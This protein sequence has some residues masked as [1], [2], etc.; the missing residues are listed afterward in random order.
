MSEKKVFF[1][2]RA[3]AD[4]RWAELI[5]RAVKDAGHQAFSEEDIPIGENIV[6][7][8]ARGADAYCT[9]AVLSPAYFRSEHCVA[10][11][12]SALFRDPLGRRGSVFPVRVEPVEI[13]NLYA[14]L[15][16]L[17][18]VGVN[19]DIALQKLMIT[20]VRRGQVE[21]TELPPGGRNLRMIEHAD[22]NR[23]AMIEKV[24]TIWID[25][26]LKHSLFQ[27]V[28]ILLDLDERPDA[29]ARPLDLLVRRP[30]EGERPLPA[31][32]KIVDVFDSMD[33]SLLILGAPGAGKT[34]LLLEL[35]RDLLDRAIDN[36]SHPIPVVFPLST[37]AESQKSL[38]EWLA[39]ELNLRYDV[40][41]KIAQEWVASDQVL[42]LLDGLDE[43]KAEHRAAC[44]KVINAFR[45]S[46]GF[47]PLA[48]ASRTTDYESLADPIRL[49]GAIV[50]R[51]LTREQVI[52][53]LTELGS[54]GESVR[55]AV[56]EDQSL[57]ELLVSP[58]LL[59]V[60][61]VAHAGRREVPLPMSGTAGDR[62]N[63]IF[64]VYVDQMLRRRTT[65]R[66][67]T[68]KQTVH[69]LEWLAYQMGTHAQTVFYLERLQRDWLPRRQRETIRVCN[70]L[71]IGLVFG[72]VFGLAAVLVYGRVY[73]WTV[74]RVVGPFLGMVFGLVVGP[75][76]GLVAGRGSEQDIS[77]VETVRW[78]SSEF[79]DAP[80]SILGIAL[81]VGLACG[82]GV[83]LVRTPVYGLVFGL[84][85]GLVVWLV[86]ALIVGL[87]FG[88]IESRVIPNQGIVKSARNAAIFGLVFGLVG[89]LVG[90]LAGAAVGGPD[91][92]LIGV[93]G[94]LIVPLV[95]GLYTGGGSCLKHVILR[96]WLIWNGSTP[97]TYVRF[98]DHAADRVL[99][100][101]V[102]GG[103]AFIHRM[104]LDYFAAR[105]VEP[106]AATAKPATSSS[107]EAEL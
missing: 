48:I 19:D 101:K 53:Y 28:R 51:P 62:R 67:Y 104:L 64:G 107:P 39:G 61:T 68:S 31:G 63:H 4:R 33:Q 54:A 97:W 42:P 15:A 90:G 35:L 78:S 93:L 43:V 10:E 25:D 82:L 27:E 23:K 88:E 2:S 21:A 89:V 47:L 24:R 103:Y 72:L 50:V 52:E 99:L 95:V 49:H 66:R 102:G 73:G 40:P 57:W 29:V 70:V 105:Y 91:S 8:M 18:L 30:D 75:I 22:R 6:D 11:L 86:G 80:T 1:I 83:G 100:R 92:A 20:L 76:F 16:Y 37:W 65:E 13:P 44:V 56:E 17:D 87:S 36:S 55:S 71:V 46:H 74:G 12:A 32:T 79:R 26:F 96:L 84:V 81:A 58:L 98:L 94:G 60:L 59:N 77:S 41:R 3:G 106:G 34:T 38:V 5:A 69:W 85:L 14:P 7:N 45:Q 9:I